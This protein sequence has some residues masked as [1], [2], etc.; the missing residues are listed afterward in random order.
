MLERD[1]TER[2]IGRVGIQI[3]GMSI[4]DKARPESINLSES[5][6]GLVTTLE[7][8]RVEVTSSNSAELAG[9]S[10]GHST[11]SAADLDEG[12]LISVR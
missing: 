11:D 7:E 10:A 5:T 1:V 3:K 12:P 6:D 2:D 8:A 9:E 4:S